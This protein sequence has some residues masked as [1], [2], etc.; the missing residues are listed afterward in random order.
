ML[1][2]IGDDPGSTLKRGEV[3]QGRELK[4][5]SK[6]VN[7]MG[8]GA[9]SHWRP[10]KNCVEYILYCL[11]RGKETGVFLQTPPFFIGCKVTIGDLD[12]L[13]LLAFSMLQRILSSMVIN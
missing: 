9:Q 10:S 1:V 3:R 5:F 4:F 8:S 12:S 13:V 11:L 7:T 2:Y 6:W